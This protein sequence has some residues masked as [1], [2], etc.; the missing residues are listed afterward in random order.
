MAF[1][2]DPAPRARARPLCAPLLESLREGGVDRAVIVLRQGKWDI[3]AFLGQD[4]AGLGI[5]LI[6]RIIEPTASVPETLAEAL[7]FLDRCRVALGFPDIVFEPRDAFRQVIARQDATGADAV[8]GLFPCDRGH[9]A[10]MIAFDDAGRV[11]RLVIKQPGHDLEFTWSIAVWTPRFSGFLRQTVEQARAE[12]RAREL[13]VGDVL[14]LAIDQ[15]LVIETVRFADGF[16]LDAGTPDDL[17]RL[18]RGEIPSAP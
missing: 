5:E 1:H 10:D 18:L 14:Q 4:G 7:P 17:T 16:S 12:S 8:L 6:Y 11:Q 2:Q 15:G 9:K 3:P 13:Y